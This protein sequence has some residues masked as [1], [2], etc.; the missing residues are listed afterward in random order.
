[1]GLNTLPAVLAIDGGNSK[2]DVALVSPDGMVLAS[3]RGPGA[4]QEE[5]GIDGAMR[6]LGGLV[7]DVAAQA[8]LPRDGD[9][10]ARH[11]SACLAGCDLPSEEEQLTTALRAQGWSQSAIAMNDTFAVL[12]A[13]LPD[14]AVRPGDPVTPRAGVA[15]TCGAGINCVAVAPDGRIAR[16]LALGT[17]TG[18]WGAGSG[19]ARAV[20]WHAMR[21]E[22][23][24]GRPT[25]LGPGVAA[26]FG[27][28]TISDVAIAVHQGRLAEDELITLVPVL[29]DLAASGDEV[30]R[31]LVIRQAEEVCAMAVA[32]MRRLS[33][34]SAGTTVVLG[35]GLLQAGD[36]LLSSALHTAFAA[37][38]PGADIRIADVPPVT[39]AALLGLDHL[40][41]VTAAA[42]LRHCCG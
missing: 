29:F 2:T 15:V 14:D 9:L 37:Q 34:Q 12:R 32:A 39:G 18:D 20:M 6:I 22:D 1:M 38:A 4:N 26:H 30:A 27:L 5:H 36:P 41:L 23:G 40:G 10:I 11:T 7:R 13:G 19:L 24:R 8:G 35:G 3:L 17:L 33:L 28:A 25:A 16:Y 21:A 42:C 31:G